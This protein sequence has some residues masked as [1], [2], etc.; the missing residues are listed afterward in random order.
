MREILSEYENM[1][2]GVVVYQVNQNQE[3]VESIVRE[4]ETS[5]EELHDWLVGQQA[6]ALW[7]WPN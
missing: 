1:C 2:E 4:I 7:R 6:A 3:T 5:R